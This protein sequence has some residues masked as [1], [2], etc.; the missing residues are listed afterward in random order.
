[1]L[2]AWA[3]ILP[4]GVVVARLMKESL[5]EKRALLFKVHVGCQATACLFVLISFI[6]ALR[7]LQNP[8]NQLPYHHG[9]LGLA[10]VVM[11]AFHIAL[12]VAR[13]YPGP[14]LKRYI[15]ERAHWWLG[16]SLVVIALA[17]MILGI[18]LLGQFNFEATSPWFAAMAVPFAVIF[19]VGELLVQLQRRRQSQRTSQA[20]LRQEDMIMDS[21]S[22]RPNN[23]R[24]E[25]SGA[26]DAGDAGAS[27]R[28]TGASADQSGEAAFD[29]DYLEVV[30]F[31]TGGQS[32]K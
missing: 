11:T 17:T 27:G 31:E 29:A 7:H 14:Q 32:S 16:R 6:Y 3:I 22:G 25:R 4:L 13:P 20:K 30:G 28:R 5:D 24:G 26:D 10:L 9:E 12:A 2:I 23:G 15:W 19:V 18:K 8:W 21:I 1:M